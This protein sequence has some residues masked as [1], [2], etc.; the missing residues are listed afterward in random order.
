MLP[1]VE[2]A[3]TYSNRIEIVEGD[4]AEHCLGIDSAEYYLL[5]D[6][7]DE[8]FHCAA[9]TKFND[10]GDILKRT[11]VF[12]TRH[13]VEFCNT[14]KSKRLHHISTAYVAGRRKGIVFENELDTGQSFNNTYEKSKCDAEKVLF[15]LTP[16]NRNLCTIYRPSII[17]G[18]TI[19]GYTK[20]YDNMYVFGRGLCR[21][22]K[23]EIRNKGDTEMV[24]RNSNLLP[25][26]LRIQ[27]DRY[28]TINL[29]PVDYVARAIVAISQ[30]Q[31]SEGKTF[32]IVNPSPP[33]L[34]ELSEW[35]K[36]ATGIHSMRIVSQDEWKRQPLSFQEKLFLQG[37]E[38]FQPYMFGE[39]YFD[40]TN[41]TNFLRGS[42]I[43]CPMITEDLIRLFI[44][45]ALCT[46]WGKA[47][48]FVT[49]N[50]QKKYPYFD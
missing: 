47:K 19:T 36:A 2:T 31:K 9:A 48:I 24:K 27:G 25:V 39:P 8:V 30:E 1:S 43:M 20:N 28:G 38:S 37:T 29:V 44:Q 40:C 18:D 5:A 26:S 35:M 46:N 16:Q 50:A 42:G 23:Y 32:H 15:E 12:G 41:T 21:L 33:T 22:K 13:V 10:E 11:N 45:H 14:G 34:G 49:A 17:I 6:T 7:I 4:I 3:S